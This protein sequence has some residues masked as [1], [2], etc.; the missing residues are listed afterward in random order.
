MVGSSSRG[1]QH[2][3]TTLIKPE[4]GAPGA[5]VSAIAGTG[6]G[7]GPFGGTSGASPMVAGSAALLLQVEPNLTPPETKA[8]LMNNGDTNIDTDPFT[9]LAPITRIGGG[10]VRADRA[11]AAPAAAWDDDTLQ[12]ALSFGFVDA[13]K[14]VQTLHKNVRVR[15]YSDEAINYSISSAFRYADDE[16]SGAISVDVSPKQV[17]VPA[18]SDRTFN[19]KMTI[20]GAWLPGNFMNS[21]SQGANPDALTANEFDG[22]LT[23]DDGAHPIHM[24][25]HVLPRKDANVVGRKVLNF[26][27]GQDLVSLTNNGV[28]T[29]QNDA[30]SLLAV[31]PNQPEG[32]FGGQAPMPDIRA[33]GI[34]TFPVGAGFCSGQPSFIWA[35]A[36]NTWERQEHLLPV[37]HQ[38]I[39]DTNQD[40]VDDYVV[41]N[42]D[43]SGLNT[44]SDGRQV[45]YAFDLAAGTASAFFFAEHSMNTGNTVL[46]ICGEQIGLTGTDML[47][48][49]VDME[50]IAEDFYYGGPGDFVG[51]LTVTPLGEQYFGIPSDIAPKGNGSMTVIDFG[52][53]PGNSAEQGVMLIT[54]GDRGTGARGGATQ[55]TEALLFEAK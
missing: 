45:T 1:P 43:L 41:L 30:F 11:V 40:G 49:N 44:I 31:S 5:S 21:G 53:F 36:I 18:G 27:A 7:T 22:Y 37:S 6:T 2:E 50:V 34:N 20:N 14:D 24:A 17:K 4:I 35:F 16:A 48:T 39:L 10:E 42:R 26:S 13:E 23:L 9:G 33:V 38:V 28:G 47:S 15:N 12:G 25:W 51:G 3:N 32:G 54:N 19:V 55:D 8:R 52:A 46:L 29:A